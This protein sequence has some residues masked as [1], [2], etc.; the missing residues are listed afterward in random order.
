[1]RKA[2]FVLSLVFV[3][4]AVYF[5]GIKAAQMQIFTD[6]TASSS[7]PVRF[8]LGIDAA[9]TTLSMGAVNSWISDTVDNIGGSVSSS[10]IN[11]G[12]LVDASFNIMLTAVPGLSFGPKIGYLGAFPGNIKSTGYFY[13]N[14]TDDYDY[15]GTLTW[16]L[17]G[18]MIP[19][20]IGASYNYHIPDTILTL[21]GSFY[22]GAAFAHT[23]I[24]STFS[25]A[26]LNG[27][28]QQLYNFDVPYSGSCPM[29]DITANIGLAL[30]ESFKLLLN[31]GYRVATVSQ[32]T[33]DQ[34]QL[35]TALGDINA[36]DTAKDWNNNTLVFDYSGFILGAEA[37]FTF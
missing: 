9:F 5:S 33:A 28:D 3:L 22:F 20:L 16:D 37:D 19:V 7:S 15:Y 13:D 11:S 12:Y 21:G 29:V 24:K 34:T 18:S 23:E 1:M 14:Y 25:G 17:Y 32:M 4:T 30:S 10:N 36:G 2:I 27:T 8:G 35:G 6:E 31:L 26:A